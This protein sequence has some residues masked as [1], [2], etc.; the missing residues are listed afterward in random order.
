MPPSEGDL[1][2]GLAGAGLEPH[3]DAL[4]AQTAPSVR[5]YPAEEVEP[6]RSQY[7]DTPVPVPGL[8]ADAVAI[9][10][11]RSHKLALMADGSVLGWG[12]N[13]RGALGDGTRRD[14]REPVAVRDLAGVMAIA[15][16]A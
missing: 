3:A 10:G 12:S 16:G 4:L 1:R 2:A 14:R 8:G 15:A 5:L 6:K 7:F 13:Q 9:A 11:S